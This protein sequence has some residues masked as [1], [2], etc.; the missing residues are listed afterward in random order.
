MSSASDQKFQTKSRHVC[1]NILI[2]QDCLSIQQ[3]N[4]MQMIAKVYRNILILH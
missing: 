1:I 3:S 4:S 2:K